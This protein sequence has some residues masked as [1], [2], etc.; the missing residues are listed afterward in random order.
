MRKEKTYFEQVPVEIAE[1]VLE[2]ATTVA[3]ILRAS[4]T[5]FPMLDREVALPSS[6]RREAFLPMERR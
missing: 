1:T 2:K 4:P 3:E 6:K 5:L